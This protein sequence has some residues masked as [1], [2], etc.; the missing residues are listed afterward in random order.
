MPRVP[1]SVGKFK[2][3]GQVNKNGAGGDGMGD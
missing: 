2:Y 1:V 3:G